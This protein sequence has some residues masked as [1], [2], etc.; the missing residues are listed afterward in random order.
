MSNEE[1]LFQRL[2]QIERQIRP[3]T[4]VANAAGD[5]REELAPRVGEAVQALIKE[6]ADV[7]ADFRME[8]LVF[9]IK[10]L[11]RN[12]SNLNF[13]MDQFKNVIDFIRIA[14]PLFKS[15]VPQLIT[16]VDHLEQH[17]VFKLISVGTEALKKIGSTCSVEDMHQIG[18]GLVHLVGTL[19]KLTAPSTLELIDRA[20]DL[21]SRVDVDQAPA[22]TIW[23][24][25]SAMG[26]KDVQ[27][28]LG[29]LMELTKGLT[30]L[31]SPV[32][33]A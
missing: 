16:V 31:K 9:F 5:L 11:M 30:A 20:A 26:N 4:A 2:D 7:E 32:P 23:G 22:L 25:M 14:E 33:S 6:L 17:G 13:A 27:Q 28:G 8:D 29:I 24:V 1:L 12:I 21:P 10:K 19:K 15:T 3:L 18:D